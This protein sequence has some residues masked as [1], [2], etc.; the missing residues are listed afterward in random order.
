V[1]SVGPA[2]CGKAHPAGDFVETIQALD[3]ERAYRLHVPVTY[4]PDRLAPLVVNYHGYDRSALDQETYSNLVPLSERE[5]FVLATPEGGG[6]PRAWDIVGVYA[7]NGIDDVAFT[8]SLLNSV[9]GELCI[10][11]QRI[12]ATGISNGGEMA[13]QVAC[14]LSAGFAAVAPVAGVVYQEDCA[15]DPVPIVSFHGTLDENVPFD[16]ARPAMAEWAGHNGCTGDLV[17]EQVTDR[18]S[19]ESYAGCNGNDVVLYVIDGGGHTWPGAED[20]AGGVGPTTHKI[21][22]NE[23]IWQFFKDHPKP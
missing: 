5:G 13:S 18:V 16:E 8:V 20:D 15:G 12:Y 6:S 11:P 9:A 4:R 17:V 2:G 7:E 10:D 22:A 3:A 19:R 14:Y 21:S 1:S 23:L